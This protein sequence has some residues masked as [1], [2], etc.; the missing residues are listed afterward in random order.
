MEWI[1]SLILHFKIAFHLHVLLSSAFIIL[2]V[3]VHPRLDVLQ[4]VDIASTT[5]WRN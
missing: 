2:F 3:C 1:K 4:N 5:R